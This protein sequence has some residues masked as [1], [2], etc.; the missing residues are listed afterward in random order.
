MSVLT[1]IDG[2][3]RFDAEKKNLVLGKSDTEPCCC[4]C[5]PDQL[6]TVEAYFMVDPNHCCNCAKFKF[7]VNDRFVR[8]FNFNNFPDCASQ[9]KLVVTNVSQ[10]A[11]TNGLCCVIQLKLVC[12]SSPSDIFQG[13]S[14]TCEQIF[15]PGICHTNITTV[16]ITLPNGKV[17]VAGLLPDGVNT[18]VEICPDDLT[19][20]PLRMPNQAAPNLPV[21]GSCPCCGRALAQRARTKYHPN[22][23]MGTVLWNLV[24]KFLF[25]GGSFD[26][27]PQLQ[28][29][30]KA[31]D[32]VDLESWERHHDTLFDI[33]KY[34][35]QSQ[36]LPFDARAAR[37]IIRRALS[38]VRATV[39]K[40]G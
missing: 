1:I 20:A 31:A 34:Q 12:N 40:Y 19:P 37:V 2:H 30:I 39:A 22:A 7:Y 32:L 9:N 26:L 15:G 27:A 5:R 3:L 25:Q 17:V 28:K 29:Y 6:T 11:T 33:L 24:Q 38:I 18:P 8:D 4:G 16:Q 23:G 14:A 13:G 21:P 10:G 36:E 35:A